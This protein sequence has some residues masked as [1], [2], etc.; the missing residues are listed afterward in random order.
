M[1]KSI[2]DRLKDAREMKDLRQV[3][4]AKDLFISNKVLSSYERNVSLPTIENLIALC[5][6]YNVSADYILGIMPKKPNKDGEKPV[7]LTKD[8]KKLLSYFDRLNQENKDAI[9]GLSIIYVKDQ[10]RKNSY[11]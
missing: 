8:Q 5:E 3:D 11:Q 2:G 4:V 6:Y 1:K 10:S 9:I 7:Y